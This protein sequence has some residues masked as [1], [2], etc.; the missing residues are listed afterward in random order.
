MSVVSASDYK[1]LLAQAEFQCPKY[2]NIT[3]LCRNPNNCPPRPRPCETC[4]SWKRYKRVFKA[5][6]STQAIIDKAFNELQ[7]T[8]SPCELPNKH[9]DE[10]TYFEECCR[11]ISARHQ[12]E[13][14]EEGGIR[15]K[16]SKGP[17]FD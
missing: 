16:Q 15:V 11:A 14:I 7:K 4:Q 2:K 17:I 5:K 6:K 12:L 1:R 9:Y 10:S 13:R 3:G 8:C